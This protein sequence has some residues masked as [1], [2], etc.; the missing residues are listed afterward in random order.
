[1]RC[2]ARLIRRVIVASG[3]RNARAISAVL[4][5]PTA[6]SVSAICDAGD[7][8][9]WQHRNSRISVSSASAGGLVGGRGAPLLRQHPPGH[10]VLPPPAGLLAAQQVGQP[11]GRDGDQPAARVVR[12]AV[13]RPTV[14]RPRS[15]PPAPRPRR[16]RNARS[17]V[18]ARRGPAAPARA[19]G[20]R[21][22]SAAPVSRPGPRCRRA[23]AARPRTR[24]GRRG[25]PGRRRSR[26][27]GRSWRTPRSCN[28]PGPPASP[29]TARR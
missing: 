19:A 1:M 11:A 6:R 10:R 22:V 3:T 18:P 15:A 27:P 23:P 29:G 28:P 7:S 12:Y 20:P 14:R 24:R 2:L 25:R 16:C 5:P 4:S 13:A 21:R 26:W 17:G 9:G 8:A